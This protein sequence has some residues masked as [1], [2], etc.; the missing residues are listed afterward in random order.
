MG[1]DAAGREES[2]FWS[3]T[4]QSRPATPASS[5]SQVGLF[6][7][8]FTGTFMIRALGFSCELLCP[9]PT[10]TPS[11][12]VCLGAGRPF[13]YVHLSMSQRGFLG[14]QTL[15]WVGGGLRS[16]S[17]SLL[18]AAPRATVSVLLGAP[19]EPLPL[20]L[21]CLER[22]PTLFSIQTLTHSSRHASSVPLLRGTPGSSQAEF[23]TPSSVRQN[24][25]LSMI[26]SPPHCTAKLSV[27]ESLTLD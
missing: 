17:P 19:A 16:L 13:Q 14:L 22:L 5:H 1:P 15:C 12:R 3:L 10:W 2:W 18:P 23:S 4:C 27:W 7:A 9:P 25:C 6:P 8:I 26:D 21:C 20:C 24:P 11:S